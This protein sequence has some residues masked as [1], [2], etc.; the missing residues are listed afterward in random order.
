LTPP[1]DHFGIL[2]PFYERFIPPKIPEKLLA[3]VNVPV[4]GIVL[5]AGGG[6]GRVAQ[7]LHSKAAQMVVADQSR[8]MLGEARKKDGL[9]PLCSYVELMPFNDSTFDRIF[10]VDALHHVASQV[11]TTDEFWRILKPGGRIVIEEPDIRSFKVKLIAAAEKLALM[12]SH[13]LTPQAIAGLFR[14]PDAKVR[15]EAD[16]TTAWIIVEK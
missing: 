4:N 10:M 3:L 2:A 5:D 8:N 1:I 12:R 16:G 11:N 6:T 9:Q 15:I 13:F 7:F 14:S